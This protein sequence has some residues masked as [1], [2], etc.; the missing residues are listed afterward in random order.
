VTIIKVG[1]FI[2]GGYATESWEGE[3][4][5]SFYFYYQVF[6]AREYVNFYNNTVQ[7]Q[8]MSKLLCDSACV[9]N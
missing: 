3:T 9:N 4:Y 6:H 1:N 2:F 8:C 7:L 5:N